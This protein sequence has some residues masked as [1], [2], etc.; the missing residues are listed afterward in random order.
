LDAPCEDS[1]SSS[2]AMKEQKKG[3]CS[4]PHDTSGFD[5]EIDI[6]ISTQNL[7]VAR[8]ALARLNSLE[9]ALHLEACDMTRDGETD[10]QSYKH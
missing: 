10:S 6:K 8:S 2:L 4:T 9:S 7:T 3:V 5:R 1:S